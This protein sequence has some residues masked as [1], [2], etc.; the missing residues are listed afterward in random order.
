MKNV[1]NPIIEV[2]NAHGIRE[3]SLLTR[4]LMNRRIFLQG[5]IDSNMADAFLSEM[6]FLENES[7]EPVTIYIDS[8]GGEITAGLMIYDIICSS[9]LEINI[10][11]TGM[12]ASMAAIIFA[13]GK[14][15]HRFILRHS[16][17]MIHEP[18]LSGNIGASAS[19]I[20]SLSQSI[21]EVRDSVNSILAKHTGKTV[22]EINE[23]TVYDNVMNAEKAV[24]FGICDE[25]LDKIL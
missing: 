22:E 1:W 5:E 16:K 17:V 14:K 25:I 13:S 20:K 3:V 11:C 12:A 15:G 10:I 2:E 18:Q 4:H 8:T 19:S 6:I 9:S 21:M 24:E 23:A 7:S